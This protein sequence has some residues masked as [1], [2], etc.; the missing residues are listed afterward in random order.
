M[1]S[2]LIVALHRIS[3][4]IMMNRRSYCLYCTYLVWGESVKDVNWSW[5]NKATLTEAFHSVKT[6]H[7]CPDLMRKYP[8]YGSTQEIYGSILNL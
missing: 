2:N 8:F 4:M 5:R 3:E 1:L 7:G 6:F